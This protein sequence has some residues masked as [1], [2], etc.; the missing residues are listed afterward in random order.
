MSVS[1]RV[2][3]KVDN[4]DEALK[5]SNKGNN[6]S[7]ISICLG[8]Q[9]YAKR[10]APVDTGYLKGSITYKTF[11]KDGGGD[12]PLNVQPKENQGFVG[13]NVEYALYQEFG[14]RNNVPPQPFMRPAILI[15]E[16]PQQAKEIADLFNAEMDKELP[17]VK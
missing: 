1:V 6:A 8:V 12:S 3:T 15:A 4:L 16:S 9:G 17:R 13:T 5:A 2:S 14:T 10:L 11:T 7:I